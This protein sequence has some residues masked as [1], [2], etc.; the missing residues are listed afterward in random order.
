VIG[1]ISAL[2]INDLL[3]TAWA[4]NEPAEPEG[5]SGCAN[6]GG[7]PHVIKKLSL[8]SLLRKKSVFQAKWYTTTEP[9]MPDFIVSFFN[10]L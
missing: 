10:V 4:G 5:S 2:L 7:V 3:L 9:F 6:N 1:L 8:V